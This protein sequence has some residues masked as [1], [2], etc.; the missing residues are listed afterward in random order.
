MS[1]GA[2]GH[3]IAVQSGQEAMHLARLQRGSAPLDAAAQA[4]AWAALLAFLD[5]A[6]GRGGS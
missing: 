6:I 5:A 4:K 1:S 3:R 2:D